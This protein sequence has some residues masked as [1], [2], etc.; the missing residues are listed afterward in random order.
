VASAAGIS[1]AFTPRALSSEAGKTVL[2][3]SHHMRADAKNTEM[4]QFFGFL[5]NDPENPTA[6]TSAST[7]PQ[8]RI[9]R[10]K[11]VCRVTGLGRSFI[12]QLQAARRFPRSIEIGARAV[13]GW[14]V[15][16]EN[17]LI[18]ASESAAP[19]RLPDSS[20]SA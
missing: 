18:A 2:G 4:E 16:Y 5:D 6:Q 14:K 19:T 13:D 9:L 7:A 3:G 10:L 17:G 12:Y 15:K 8:S 11:E 1:A 20:Q